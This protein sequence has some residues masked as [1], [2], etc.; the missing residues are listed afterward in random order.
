MAASAR[1]IKFLNWKINL[2]LTKAILLTPL[3]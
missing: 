1:I 3:I 2:T